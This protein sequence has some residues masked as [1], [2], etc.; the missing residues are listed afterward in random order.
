MVCLV[1]AV[2]MA[3]GLSGCGS[4][5]SDQAKNKKSDY[6]TEA[7]S[8]DMYHCE[9]VK[10]PEELNRIED[11]QFREGDICL[12]GQAI[13]AEGNH[14]VSIYR[15]TG[16]QEEW[17]KLFEKKYTYSKKENQIEFTVNIDLS[18]EAVTLISSETVGDSAADS[19][20]M[21]DRAELFDYQ[22]RKIMDLKLPDHCDLTNIELD[23]NGRGYAAIDLTGSGQSEDAAGTDDLSKI[24]SIDAASGNTED[25]VTNSDEYKFCIIGNTIY[26]ENLSYDMS[27]AKKVEVPGSVE[28]LREDVLKWSSIDNNL[29][30]DH[31]YKWDIIG[32]DDGEIVCFGVNK[33]GVYRFQ[34]GKKTKIGKAPSETLKRKT[35]YAY[36]AIFAGAA[37][38]V[39]VPYYD[40]SYENRLQ[41]FC[42]EEK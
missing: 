39:F 18:P 7:Y 3:V 12:G 35:N 31:S 42:Y 28:S 37:G 4:N 21:I 34:N 6:D 19:E 20:V 16:S 36:D 1:L 32:G 11:M 23:K 9:E 33:Y 24:V 8:R 25:L 17:I 5:D 29:S 15:R 27:A 38:K 14:I 2:G 40:D 22:G 26:S 10:I 30:D 13:D 41:L